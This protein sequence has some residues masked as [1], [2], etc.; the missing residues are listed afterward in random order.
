MQNM[1]SFEQWKDYL[2]QNV[3]LAKQAGTSENTII[4]MASKLGNLLAAQVDPSNRE[5]RLLKELWE[6][7]D[8]GDRKSLAKC[9]TKMVSD[10]V[11]H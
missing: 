10:G 11:K 8:E 7:G 2:S 1:E 9:I 4:E 6:V 5:Q 3:Q